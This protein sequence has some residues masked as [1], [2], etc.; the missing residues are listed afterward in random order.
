M[1]PELSQAF[2]E[3]NMQARKPQTYFDIAAPR[4]S[5]ADLTTKPSKRSN[6]VLDFAIT[7]SELRTNSH[8]IPGDIEVIGTEHLMLGIINEAFTSTE[9]TFSGANLPRRGITFSRF[10]KD[11]F[12]NLGAEDKHPLTQE[13]LKKLFTEGAVVTTDDSYE[14]YTRGA[15]RILESASRIATFDGT[16]F[17]PEHILYAI[18]KDRKCTA[19]Y[20]LLQHDL[21]LPDAINREV[22]TYLTEKRL[23]KL[24]F[25]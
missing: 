17:D 13:E 6:D 2:F 7:Y 16:S 25:K 19:Y 5:F 11:A 23:G 12:E 21:D 1:R 9:D 10:I 4:F 18:T 20:A 24:K 15:R 22:L 8:F 3:L 14:V